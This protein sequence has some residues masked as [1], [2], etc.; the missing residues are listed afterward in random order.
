ME[1]KTRQPF[2]AIY[3]RKKAT[4]KTLTES[5]GMV[6]QELFEDAIAARLL[7]AGPV[8]WV[9]YNMDGNPDKEFDLE[10]VIPVQGEGKPGKFET[11]EMPEFK[12]ATTTYVGPWTDFGNVYQQLI[13]ELMQQ[14]HQMTTVCREMYINI[15]FEHPERNIT[16]IQVGIQ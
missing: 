4:L 2:N 15:D 5:V 10:V 6:A 11:K 12:C 8:Y 1:I 3:A 7:P 9:Y 14:G 13:G 16:E